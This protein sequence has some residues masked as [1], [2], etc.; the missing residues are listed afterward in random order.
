MPMSYLSN[1]N[2]ERTKLEFNFFYKH[3]INDKSSFSIRTK[4]YS[5]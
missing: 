3:I 5:R 1:D 4:I 2:F